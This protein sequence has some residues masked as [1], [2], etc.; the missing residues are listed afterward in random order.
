MSV[1]RGLQSWSFAIWLHRGKEV[2]RKRKRFSFCMHLVILLTFFPWDVYYYYF[3]WFTVWFIV[4]CK[5]KA[6]ENQVPEAHAVPHV[7]KNTPNVTVRTLI[8]LLQAHLFLTFSLLSRVKRCCFLT[9]S[10]WIFMKAADLRCLALNI[11]KYFARTPEIP[12]FHVCMSKKSQT[13]FMVYCRC[14]SS[15]P[16]IENYLFIWT[17]D[18][19]CNKG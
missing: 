12:A 10:L 13:I 7:G 4:S 9:S 16:V 6:Y 3:L 8:A 1:W 11:P 18:C 15:I 17:R 2:K 14:F 19:F 5:N